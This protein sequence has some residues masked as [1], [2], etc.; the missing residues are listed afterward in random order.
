MSS[1]EQTKRRVE[2]EEELDENEIERRLAEIDD[3]VGE[4]E[5]EDDEEDEEDD[6]EDEDDGGRRKRMKRARNRYIDVEAEV[7]DS[8]EEVEDEEEGFGVDDGFI[9][10]DEREND[11]FRRRAAAENE[12][13]DRLRRQTENAS[14]EEVA[15]DLRKR[16][17][18]M[19]RRKDTGASDNVPRQALMPSVEDPSLWAVP[20]K[21]GREREIVITIIRKAFDSSST[22]RGTNMAILSAFCRDSIP[23]KIYVEARRPEAVVEAIS[24]I[25]GVYAR[26][27]DRL[28]LVPIEEMVDLLKLTRIEHEIKKG[29]WVRFKRGK[30][31][32]D[33]AQ[34]ID[35]S[36]N[37]EDVGVK[38]VPRI[39]MNPSEQEYILDSRG[40]KRRRN[41]G[42]GSNALNKR[43]TQQLFV[44]SDIERVYPNSCTGRHGIIKFQN[45]DYRNGFCEKDVKATALVIEDVQPTLSE[46][47]MFQR[48][49]GD[50][51]GVNLRQLAQI[52]QKEN[53]VVIQPGDHVEVFEGEQRGVRGIVDAINGEIIIINME[54]NEMEGTKVE[55]Q[56]NQV[57]KTFKA[58]DHV[59]VGSGDHID[60][61]GMVVKVEGDTTTFLSDLTMKEVT[62]FSKDL[63]E[64]AEVGS[65]LA[66]VDG[67]NV[68]D[69][70]LHNSRAAVIYNIEREGFR[71]LDEEGN[72]H[73]VPPRA[74][75]QVKNAFSVC[76]DHEGHEI[77]RGDTM[78]EIEGDSPRSGK[79]IQTYQSGVVFLY[80][81]D[82]SANS[83]VWIASP[84][85]LTPLTP[86][87]VGSSVKDSLDKMNPAMNM[88]L[89]AS[90]GL[91]P[92]AMAHVALGGR[93]KDYFKGRHVVVV[94]G[95]YKGYRGLI[96]ETLPNGQARVELHTTNK[97][98]TFPLVLLKE[99]DPMTGLSRPLTIGAPPMGA[100]STGYGG[101]RS[102]MGTPFGA[103]PNGPM[104]P[105]G[106]PMG[107]RTGYSASG[108]NGMGGGTTYGG[109]VSSGANT[110]YGGGGFGG[111]TSY[112]GAVGGGATNYGGAMGG[113]ATTY[114][115]GAGGGATVYGGVGG[116]A[117]AYGNLM[118]GGRTPGPS[119]YTDQSGG[120]VPAYGVNFGRTPRAQFGG[121]RTPF[122]APNDGSRTP[123]AGPGTGPSPF[124]GPGK[125]VGGVTP[126]TAA[127]MYGGGTPVWSAGS[128]TPGHGF[129]ASGSATP[130]HGSGAEGSG[131]GSA[132]PVVSDPRLRGQAAGQAGAPTPN[133]YATAPT[134]AAA[135]TPGP[136][137]A[138]TPGGPTPAAL[139]ATPAAAPTPASAPTPGGW[140]PTP[141]PDGAPTPGYGAPTPAASRH[142][143]YHD[144]AAAENAIIY[145]V[146]G[147]AVRVIKSPTASLIGK[148]VQ[149]MA[150]AMGEPITDVFVVEH[151]ETHQMEELSL[152]AMEIVHPTR[153][154]ELCIVLHGEHRGAKG[155]YVQEDEA[156][157]AHV[158]L[159]I[160]SMMLEFPKRHVAV[161]L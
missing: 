113:G 114:G 24:S 34:V 145:P 88:A 124:A 69:L 50:E 103:A 92:T 80:N 86:R 115:G 122:G 147:A 71:I 132:A 125:T 82:L 19:A 26:T 49:E 33:L 110:G 119:H 70:V 94:K 65:G 4:D 66:T 48:G 36:D 11:T 148:Q 158:I 20:V 39:D 31:Q 98:E 44:I 23:G 7:D 126:R 146:R 130:Y 109:G 15:R 54:H 138:P 128:K 116:G 151:P 84:H 159:K 104:G 13:L 6:E 18:R 52:K 64:A 150:P 46:I 90:R 58:G 21:I 73:M 95:P 135:P 32:G 35:I 155:V 154:K 40:N 79:V 59:K 133:P 22:G 149:V 106:M 123:F 29:G 107:G 51:N 111:N 131:Q 9:D 27:P 121:G 17:G 99:K 38:F 43:P 120:Q 63:R 41:L 105:P 136:Q 53:Q 85:R 62:V 8:D 134:P 14:A 67:F 91:D 139:A 83:G 156:S 102:N 47:E 57:R 152:D 10:R 60:E 161:H 108:S 45:E 74:L 1:T 96:K 129:G 127:T 42:S 72:S 144:N 30:Y 12:N 56:L 137:T 76:I 100:S 77:R 68:Y 61:T 140:G 55:V 37:G 75:L 117:T 142:P 141:G 160:G 157:G 101:G 25:V 93:T 78:K 16:Y 89:M 97:N 112:G 2:D 5:E 87:H 28:F 81:R 118:G 3:E 153:V 143:A